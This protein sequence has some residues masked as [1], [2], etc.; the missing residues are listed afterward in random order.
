MARILSARLRGVASAGLFGA[1]TV[2]N[3]HYWKANLPATTHEYPA[4]EVSDPEIEPAPAMGAAERAGSAAR[5]FPP[6]S[7]PADRLLPMKTSM[8]IDVSVDSGGLS[9]FPAPSVRPAEEP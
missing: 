6:P 7:V 1:A 5:P 8:P 4:V 9:P 2:L 3:V